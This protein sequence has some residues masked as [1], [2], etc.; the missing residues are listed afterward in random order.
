METKIF[1]RIFKRVALRYGFI[2]T[3]GVLHIEFDETITVVDLQKSD[4]GNYFYLNIK[5][6]IK[7]SF[8]LYDSVTSALKKLPGS[9]FQRCPAVYD[10][11]FDLD[12]DN[13]EVDKDKQLSTM[14]EQYL[15]PYL[16][17][18]RSKRNIIDTYQSDPKSFFLLPAVKAELGIIG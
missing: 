5:T 9:I 17:K 10:E 3:S 12:L 15:Q 16:V 14:F 1:R 6:F 4:Y 2:F 13:S 7:G 11:I 18:V 8:G